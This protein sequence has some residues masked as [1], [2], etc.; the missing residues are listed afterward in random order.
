MPAHVNANDQPDFKN[1][2]VIAQASDNGDTPAPDRQIPFK[3]NE[4]EGEGQEKE[5]ETESD[6][7]SKTK[8][9]NFL[10]LFVG[11]TIFCNKFDFSAVATEYFHVAEYPDT[12]SCEPIYISI[13]NIR[14]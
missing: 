10:S 11:Y 7:E 9:D 5:K 6:S 14:V 3:E 8:N 13:R 1:D 12:P 2:V 4:E